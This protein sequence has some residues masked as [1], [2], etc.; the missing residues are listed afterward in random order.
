MNRRAFVEALTFLGKDDNID[1]KTLESRP[2]NIASEMAREA[3]VLLSDEQK[4]LY[5][6]LFLIR[7]G[8]RKNPS[9][10]PSACGLTDPELLADVLLIT[11]DIKQYKKFTQP[12][13]AKN[14]IEVGIETVL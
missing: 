6:H 2:S 5:T 3:K 10:G 11:G 14:K 4:R 7:P 8:V 12:R 9:E 1:P 13:S